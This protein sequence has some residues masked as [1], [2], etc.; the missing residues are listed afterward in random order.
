[1]VS[2]ALALGTEYYSIFAKKNKRRWAHDHAL[3][4]MTLRP[5]G[6]YA[7]ALFLSDSADMLLMCA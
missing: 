3:L 2:T 1:M 7:H 5:L 6:N 4:R